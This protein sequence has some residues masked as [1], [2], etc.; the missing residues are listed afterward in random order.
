VRYNNGK[1]GILSQFWPEGHGLEDSSTGNALIL[2]SVYNEE[3]VVIVFRRADSAYKAAFLASLKSAF[4]LS[5][6]EIQN[7]NGEE[8]AVSYSGRNSKGETVNLIFSAAFNGVCL[9][10]MEI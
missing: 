2:Y 9:E 7:W 8:G 1:M 3:M 5:S 4:P 10:K 6:T